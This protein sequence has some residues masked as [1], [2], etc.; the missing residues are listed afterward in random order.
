MMLQQQEA[1]VMLWFMACHYFCSVTEMRFYTENNTTLL[2]FQHAVD[3]LYQLLW[4]PLHTYM[5]GLNT[6]P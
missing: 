5:E 4:A 2:L 6:V 1:Y 3:A